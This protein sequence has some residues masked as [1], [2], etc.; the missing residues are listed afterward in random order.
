MAEIFFFFA[1]NRINIYIFLGWQT[2]RLKY[3]FVYCL[4]LNFL[5][6]ALEL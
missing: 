6:D 5:V 3:G 2:I 4:L 1:K